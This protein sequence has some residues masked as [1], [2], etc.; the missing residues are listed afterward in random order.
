MISPQRLDTSPQSLPSNPPGKIA[1]I[2]PSLSRRVSPAAGFSTKDQQKLLERIAALEKEKED[3]QTQNLEIQVRLEAKDLE[4]QEAKKAPL[5][6]HSPNGST[7]M[8]SNVLDMGSLE[9]LEGLLLG[10]KVQLE[11][12]E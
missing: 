4:L 5:A 8:S 6:V 2:P 11:T 9:E 7:A 3:L 12:D 10:I 1:N